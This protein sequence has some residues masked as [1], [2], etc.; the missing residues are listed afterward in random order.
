VFEDIG[1]DDAVKGSAR[2]GAAAGQRLDV[3]FDQVVGT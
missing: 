3:A 1:Q 2:V